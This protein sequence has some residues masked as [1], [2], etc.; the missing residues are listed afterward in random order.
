MAQGR[1]FV[2]AISKISLEP[3]RAYREWFKGREGNDFALGAVQ[4]VTVSPELIVAKD[5]GNT[6]SASR[7]ADRRFVTMR[8]KRR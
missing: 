7:A 2:L 4:F 3:E 6:A 5:L 1:G 8:L